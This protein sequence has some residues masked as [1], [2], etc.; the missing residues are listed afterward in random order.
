VPQR[1]AVDFIEGSSYQFT[2]DS[3]LLEDGL[4]Q[5]FHLK[6]ARTA[7]Q[8]TRRSNQLVDTDSNQRIFTFGNKRMLLIDTAVVYEPPAQKIPVDIIVLSKNPKLYISQLAG[9]FDCKMY[10]FDASNS[11]WKINYWKKDCE[12][13]LL[14]CHSVAEQ[15]A[16]VVEAE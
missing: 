5:N 9:V 15:G 2:G 12:K 11:L 16:F 6:P 7:M 1:R 10:V 13:L 4:L 14:R 3:V 8:L